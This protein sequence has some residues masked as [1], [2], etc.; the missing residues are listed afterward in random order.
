MLNFSNCFSGEKTICLSEYQR[1][2]WVR[3]EAKLLL[4]NTYPQLEN[5]QSSILVGV[6]SA[7]L[8]LKGFSLEKPGKG[9]IYFPYPPVPASTD[10]FFLYRVLSHSYVQVKPQKRKM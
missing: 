7:E 3:H 9:I 1:C 6:L 8:P 2:L 10:F 4:L 5:L